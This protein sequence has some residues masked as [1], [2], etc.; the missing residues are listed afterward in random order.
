LVLFGVAIYSRGSWVKSQTLQKQKAGAG[1]DPQNADD[2]E[3]KLLAGV[4][5]TSG[6][7]GAYHQ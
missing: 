4:G 7:A 1:T 3:A 5:S 2:L 6:G